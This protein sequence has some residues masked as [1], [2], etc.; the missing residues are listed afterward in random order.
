MNHFYNPVKVSQGAGCL[1]RLPD[2]LQSLAAE[3]GRD[4]L[5]LV[6]SEQVLELP[7]IAELMHDTSDF[8]IH[9][10]VVSVS[11]PSVHDLLTVYRKVQELS[12]CAVV[13]IGGGSVLD[14]AKS[15]CCLHDQ[16]IADVDAMRQAINDKLFSL[17]KLPWIGVPTTA[18]TGSEVT[19]WAT[20]WDPE[21]NVKRSVESKENYAYAAL[22]D[23]NLSA[24]LPLSLAVSSALDAAAHAVES[25][26]A[27]GSNCVSK[28][29]AL[30][31]IAQIMGNIDG[32]FTNDFA[33]HDAMARGSLLAGLAFSNT[34]TTACHSVSYPLTM[35]YGIAHGTAV[36]MLLAPVLRL[37]LE[38]I[39]KPRQLL[40]ALGVTDADELDARI[41]DL[42][43]R[44]GIKNSLSQWGVQPGDL[45]LLAP[46]CITKG[47]AD[48]NPVQLTL[49]NITSIL[50]SIY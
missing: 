39:N 25:Y 8:K 5:L 17:Q 32:L 1:S 35:Q 43:Q 21:L 18:G 29:L 46:A 40:D 31:A 44:A 6:W 20:I 22:V 48:N 7:V 41:R 10:L 38:V 36:S 30:D 14:L 47:R 16:E 11:N 37:N 24:T 3:R 28:A 12:L 13:G 45:P 23:T 2:I 4:V 42:L 49:E 26:W 15:V 33:A 27:K 50:Q 34:K 9:P 19:C